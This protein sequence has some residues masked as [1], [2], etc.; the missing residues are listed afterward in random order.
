MLRSKA[1]ASGSACVDHKR[2]DSDPPA[3]SDSVLPSPL[4]PWLRQPDPGVDCTTAGDRPAA[5]HNTAIGPS[6]AWSANGAAVADVIDAWFT[7][8]AKPKC[9]GSWLL[10]VTVI[11]LAGR[12]RV[13]IDPN[14]HRPAPGHVAGP[15]WGRRLQPE[16]SRWS[17]GA[18]REFRFRQTRPECHRAR[19]SSPHPS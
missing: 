10:I 8:L 12:L 15:K 13:V 1:S 11:R 14:E 9:L 3:R 2:R 5:C 19:S 6:G 18:A 17:A 16:L 4:L 7:R